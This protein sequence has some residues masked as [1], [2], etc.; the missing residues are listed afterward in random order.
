[1]APRRRQLKNAVAEAM[2]FRR[3]AA[4]AFLAVGGALCGLAG[5]YFRLQVLEHAEYATRSEAN[6]IKPLPVVPG[7][8]LI[9][10]R[11]GRVLADNVPAFRLDV[12]PDEAGDLD[13]LIGKLSKVVALTPEDI[14]RFR[15]DR[16]AKRLSLI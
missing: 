4:I 6:R 9:L 8:G 7:R 5:W 3:R 14:E 13:V 2:Q 12:V 10:D 11:K 15:K 1:M 16:K